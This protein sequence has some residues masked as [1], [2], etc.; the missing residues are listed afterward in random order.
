MF[1]PGG[2]GSL[3]YSAR[4]RAL[5]WLAGKRRIHVPSMVAD[6]RQLDVQEAAVSAEAADEHETESVLA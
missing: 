2:L 3:L 5:K 6:M 1:V 4:D